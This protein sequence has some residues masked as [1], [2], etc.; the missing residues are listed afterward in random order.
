MKNRLSALCLLIA[1]ALVPFAGQAADRPNKPITIV[2]S[3]AAGGTLD[4][5]LD[6]EAYVARFDMRGPPSS[7]NFSKEETGKIMVAL[8]ESGLLAQPQQ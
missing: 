5:A 4:G 3:C 7:A 8:K 6:N 1:F 2:V